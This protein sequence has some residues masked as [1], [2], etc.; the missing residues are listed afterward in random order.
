M[1]AIASM[2]SVLVGT[3]L[4]VAGVAEQPGAGPE[5]I[6]PVQGG[7]VW[8]PGQNGAVPDGA[9]AQ[10]QEGNGEFLY[11]CV[12][13]AF[14]GRHVGKVRPGFSGCNFGY[15]GQEYTAESYDVL[16]NNPGYWAAPAYPGAIPDNAWAFGSE[17]DMTPLFLCLA[18]HNGGYQ[19]GKIGARTGGCNIGYGGQELTLYD[20][21]VYVY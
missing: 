18:P 17:A 7:P 19:P 4:A 13:G 14:N 1:T 12:A 16:V 15:G 6:L 2:A 9:Y 20:Y 5:R 10:G 21:Q 3:V 8:I 11:V